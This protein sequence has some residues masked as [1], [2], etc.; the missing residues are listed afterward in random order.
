MEAT[1]SEKSIQ[2]TCY[3]DNNTHK[4]SS[5]DWDEYCYSDYEILS[6]DENSV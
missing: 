5:I 6:E 4:S 1:L 3:R 2:Q